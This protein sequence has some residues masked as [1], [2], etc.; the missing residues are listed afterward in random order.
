MKASLD[1][2]ISVLTLI[3]TVAIAVV[4]FMFTQ[5]DQKAREAQNTLDALVKTLQLNASANPAEQRAGNAL[6][7]LMR[8]NGFL[9]VFNPSMISEAPYK[10]L[11][12]SM[13]GSTYAQQN[14]GAIPQ[15]RIESAPSTNE[16]IYLGQHTNDIWTN[17]TLDFPDNADPNKIVGQTY[18][19]RNNIGGVNVRS[20]PPN[21]G[22]QA[23]VTNEIETG[24][25]VTIDQVWPSPIVPSIWWSKVHY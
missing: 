6:L 3:A 25:K 1:R 24:Q 22:Q 12:D 19:V 15:Q 14:Q 23:P 7:A 13:I 5:A 4:G 20:G 2:T 11:I 8:D 18:K 21:D 17:P 10:S 16:W 9:A